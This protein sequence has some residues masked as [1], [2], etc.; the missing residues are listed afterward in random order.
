[1]G[2]A[3]NKDTAE[4]HI[5]LGG[6]VVVFVWSKDLMWYEQNLK[7][8]ILVLLIVCQVILTVQSLPNY[9]SRMAQMEDILIVHI[10]SLTL[11]SLV[12]LTIYVIITVLSMLLVR[13][14]D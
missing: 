12:H 4:L 14:Q 13:C 9:P 6:R 10:P 5:L 3:P 11:V 8:K 7:R 2:E 1:M